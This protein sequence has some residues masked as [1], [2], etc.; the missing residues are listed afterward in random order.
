M[1]INAAQRAAARAGLVTVPIGL[2]LLLA[3][4]RVGRLLGTGDY[5]VA[6]RIIGGLDLALAPG[7]VAGNRQGA[8][9][10]AR[11]GLN[12]LIGG[13]CAC[14]LRSSGGPGAALGAAAMLV[15]TTADARAIPTLNRV[16]NHAARR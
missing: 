9:L 11:A 4:T 7:L 6:L 12:L 1:D 13:Y 10:S 14:L 3:P 16:D 8:W 15:A 2:V 5:R